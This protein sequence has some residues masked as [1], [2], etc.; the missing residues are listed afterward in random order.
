MEK[1]KRKKSRKVIIQ[2]HHVSYTPEVKVKVYKGE[3]MILTRLSWRKKISMGF[4]K[5]LELWIKEKRLEAVE[6][7]RKV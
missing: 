5:A 2:D 7:S 6:L 4:I 1:K 3:H